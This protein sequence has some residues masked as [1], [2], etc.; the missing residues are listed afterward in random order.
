MVVTSPYW[1]EG[2]GS[3]NSKISKSVTSVKKGV[4]KYL[5]SQTLLHVLQV[6]SYTRSIFLK[7]RRKAMIFSIHPTL[8]RLLQMTVQKRT[9]N[10]ILVWNHHLMIRTC[11]RQKIKNWRNSAL[12]IQC[13]LSQLSEGNMSSSVRGTWITQFLGR[14]TRK[15]KGEWNDRLKVRLLT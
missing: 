3:P 10:N 14:E 15:L 4:R 11:W 2:K 6:F 12:N 5:Q 7:Q 1:Q 13:T 9:K 8:L